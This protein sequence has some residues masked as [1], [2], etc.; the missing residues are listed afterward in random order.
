MTTKLA[1]QNLKCDG[2]A[3]TIREKLSKIAGITTVTILLDKSVL[4]ISHT[5]E[6]APA[7][8]KNK[9][10]ALGYPALSERNDLLTKA[11]SY[12]SCATGKM[13]KA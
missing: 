4:T 10:A 9:L 13:S 6:V 8:I 2:C 12:I 3:T 7:V 11:K 5:D 1:I